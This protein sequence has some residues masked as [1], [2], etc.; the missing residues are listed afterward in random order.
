M[1]KLLDAFLLLRTNMHTESPILLMRELGIK[2]D[3]ELHPVF[4]Q[5]VVIRN[6]EHALK[7]NMNLI[8][9]GK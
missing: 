3:T 4:G 7:I 9:G 8:L 2:L 6:A 1:K 5:V